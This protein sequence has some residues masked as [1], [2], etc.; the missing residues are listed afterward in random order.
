MAP[1]SNHSPI[2]LDTTPVRVERKTRSFRFENKWLDEPDISRVVS[3]SWE[4]FKDFPIPS[5][6]KATGDVLSDWGTHIA[7]AWRRN[8]QDVER[9]IE[10]CKEGQIQHPWIC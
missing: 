3:S 5:L 6:L 8:N 4:G 9:Q 7:L 2:L 10:A 1:I